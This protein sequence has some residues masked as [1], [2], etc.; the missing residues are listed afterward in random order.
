MER[1]LETTY[2]Y[3]KV[4]FSDRNQA[5][6]VHVARIRAQIGI[7]TRVSLNGFVQINS[8]ADVVSTNARFRYNFREGNDLWL[9]YN[10]G[11]NLDRRREVPFL[12]TF[13]G[14]TLL[15]KYTYTFI[16]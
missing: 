15:L 10:A 5:F 2:E 9:V 1:E 11:M 14:R 4:D 6:D 13:G 3:N 7:N 16:R 8:S 12:P